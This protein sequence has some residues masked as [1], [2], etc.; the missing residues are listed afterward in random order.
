MMI[1]FY[2]WIYT[3]YLQQQQQKEQNNF[4]ANVNFNKFISQDI[5]WFLI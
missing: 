2:V 1:R 5:P 3:G 4:D